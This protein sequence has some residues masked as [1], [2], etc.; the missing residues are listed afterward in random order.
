[1]FQIIGYRDGISD[2]TMPFSNT[3]RRQDVTDA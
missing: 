1:M 2:G 3:D